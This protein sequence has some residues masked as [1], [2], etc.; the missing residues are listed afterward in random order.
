M[1][2]MVEQSFVTSLIKSDNSVLPF[3]NRPVSSVLATL[4]FAALL[5]PAVPWIMKWRR[6]VA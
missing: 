3:I 6:R 1:G 4:T 2:A 5:W